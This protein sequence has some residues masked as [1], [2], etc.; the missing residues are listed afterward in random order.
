MEETRFETLLRQAARHTTRRAVLGALIGGALLTG[1]PVESEATSR[2]Q[3][4]RRRRRQQARGPFD[5]I[6]V[7]VLRPNGVRQLN[8]SIGMAGYFQCCA[9]GR[10]SAL[11]PGPQ[12][13]VMTGNY[14]HRLW[15]WLDDGKFWFEFN[16]PMF[17]NPH[18]DLALNGRYEIPD[19]CCTG[20]PPGEKAGR[21]SFDRN[22]T[23]NVNMGGTFFTITRK[24]ISG[25]RDVL[26]ALTIP[27]DLQECGVA[28]GRLLWR[29]CSGQDI[30]KDSWGTSRLRSS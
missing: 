13:F 15:L 28:G 8:Y 27:D 26:F 11:P 10:D 4:R 6:K 14:W 1:D 24:W 29:D 17:G 22:Q 23:R 3:R 19:N 16:D 21:L 30:V 9:Y 7:T 2:A 18:V 25:S 5:L 12:S 20:I